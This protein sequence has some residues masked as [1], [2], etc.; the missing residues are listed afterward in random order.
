MMEFLNLSC[1]YRGNEFFEL[2]YIFLWWAC[3]LPLQ[4]VVVLRW[5]PVSTCS[6]ENKT[7]LMVIC[8]ENRLELFLL[9]IQ[10]NNKKKE[11]EIKT[12]I[13]QLPQTV[14]WFSHVVVCVLCLLCS[15]LPECDVNVFWPHWAST[16]NSY[17][18]LY[19]NPFLFHEYFATLYSSF[20]GLHDRK[21]IGKNSDLKLPHRQLIDLFSCT[22]ITIWSTCSIGK[23]SFVM[24]KQPLSPQIVSHCV[25]VSTMLSASIFRKFEY[26]ILA[27]SYL[28]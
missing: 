14:R 15:C 22:T 16:W 6:L 25:G 2:K 5:N 17:D 7:N 12:K 10:N 21:D 8:L 18:A 19:E 1:G 23:L 28:C 26:Q 4:K 24:H 13:F 27:S 11:N 9:K 3:S 20:T